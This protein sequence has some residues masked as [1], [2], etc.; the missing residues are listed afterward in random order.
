M[1]EKQSKNFFILVIISIVGLLYYFWPVSK[2]ERVK[3][4]ALAVADA[5]S[6]ARRTPQATPPSPAP[7]IPPQEIATAPPPANTD[8]DKFAVC[9]KKI[10]Q[11]IEEQKTP[12]TKKRKSFQARRYRRFTRN[13]T[14]AGLMKDSDV[15]PNPEQALRRLNRT[16]QRDPQNS[17][18]LL[19]SATI[20]FNRGNTLKAEELLARARTQTTRFD[21]YMRSY[22]QDVL[23]QVTTP[24]ELIQAYEKLEK[25]KTPDFSS[26][27]KMLK[28]LKQPELARQLLQDG[29]DDRKN[30]SGLDWMPEE[31]TAGL[32][33]LS[34]LG[35]NNSYPSSQELREQKNTASFLSRDRMQALLTKDCD[36]NALTPLVEQLQKEL[37]NRR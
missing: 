12:E 35:D 37:R 6:Y 24:T 31:Y 21:T 17:A 11:Q 3:Q 18:P 13:L 10:R 15:K 14:K 25:T 20:E 5:T 28:E 33:V 2:R 36:L 27:Q 29:L 8:D 19:F 34:K 4:D 23:S 1:A 7:A 26:L 22:T 32:D 30:L 9:L 16:A